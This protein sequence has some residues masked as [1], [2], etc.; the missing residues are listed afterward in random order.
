M[1]IPIV[2]SG[3]QNLEERNQP[4]WGAGIW[5]FISSTARKYGLRVDSQVDERLNA[6]LLTDAAMRLLKGDKLLFNDL[7]LSILAYNMGEQEVEKAIQQAGSRDAW[8]LI[9]KGYEN[10]KDYLARVMAAILIMKNP[11]SVR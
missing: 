6:E 11:E 4:G 8:T 2:E 9:R 1:A 3:Y 7:L 10:D 5:M